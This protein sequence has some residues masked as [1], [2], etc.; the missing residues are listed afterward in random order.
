MTTSLTPKLTETL[1][2]EPLRPRTLAYYRVRLRNR[3]HELVWRLFQLQQ[4]ERGF[5][6]RMLAERIGR[7]PEVVNRW[8][9]APGNWTL[10]TVSD[11]LLAMGT[12]PEIGAV[13]LSDAFSN[14]PA[15]A[16][17]RPVPYR[18]AKMRF[19]LFSQSEGERSGTDI[20]G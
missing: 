15:R 6:Q 19:T 17:F 11:L 8:L 13:Q 18:D 14:H 20:I 12:E 2:K 5:T 7:R 1:S 4:A 9:G 10:D 16:V 3:Y